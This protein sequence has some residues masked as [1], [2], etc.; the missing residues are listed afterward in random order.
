MQ[1]SYQQIQRHLPAEWHAQVALQLTWPHENSDWRST[2]HDVEKTFIAIAFHAS[3]AQKVLITCYDAPHREHVQNQLQAVG[4]DTTALR[5]YT[6]P[7]QDTWVRDYG[8]I[9]VYHA[10]Q[11][12][13]L[14]FV[15]NGWGTKFDYEL[16][17]LIT[18]R[19][20]QAGAFGNTPLESVNL[21]L[22]GGSIETDGQ[23][24]LLTTASCLLSEH[25][26]GLTRE[27]LEQHFA[28]LLGIQRVLW[29]QHGHLQGDDTDGHIDTLA[30]FCNPETIVY[31]ACED[32][33]D[34]HFTELKKMEQELQAFRTAQ[35]SPYQLVPLPLP[36]AQFNREARRLP[37]SY[38]NFV[39]LNGVVLAPTY[40]DPADRIALNRLQGCFPARSVIGIP[41]RSLIQQY[42]SLHCVTMQLPVGVTIA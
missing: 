16:D 31:Q 19:L 7:S 29:I 41:C 37:A 3:Q 2:L 5:F 39:I 10:G 1:A 18:Q 42:G 20:H 4:C 24:T 21:I 9:T 26:N 13:L 12:L 6:V 36:R 40:D 30:R 34:V 25:R 38:A 15:F 22:E 11:P 28:Q 14:D 27:E 17:N 8:P 33:S 35:G 32:E 23:G